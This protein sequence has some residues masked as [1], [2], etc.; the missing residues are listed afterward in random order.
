MFSAR[1]A[2]HSHQTWQSS[3][4]MTSP[5]YSCR[6]PMTVHLV[7]Q[8][9]SLTQES[10][11]ELW[12]T[13]PDGHGFGWHPARTQLEPE[14]RSGPPKHQLCIT[15]H[16]PNQRVEDEPTRLFMEVHNLFCHLRY[17]RHQSFEK[18][19]RSSTYHQV[20]QKTSMGSV[21]YL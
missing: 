8:S 13:W 10:S 14:Q 16:N 12:Y 20:K 11:V 15:T 18:A 7:R 17:E 6:S 3:R 19:K 9:F 5:S 21:A 4:L 2:S 1:S